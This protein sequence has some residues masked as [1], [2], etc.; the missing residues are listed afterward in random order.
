MRWLGR[1]WF[2]TDRL[3]PSVIID[4]QQMGHGTSNPRRTNTRPGGRGVILCSGIRGLCFCQLP[5][6]LAASKQTFK[7]S[8]NLTVFMAGSRMGRPPGLVTVRIRN[9]GQSI[10]TAGQYETAVLDCPWP[11][12]P[13]EIDL[14]SGR[15]GGSSPWHRVRQHRPVESFR[16]DRASD[17]GKNL[18]DSV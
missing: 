17:D 9:D 7:K 2:N 10:Q 13:G 8:G 3:C 4:Q 11:Q 12:T 14:V 1:N 18:R 16:K 6:N 15:N 5:D